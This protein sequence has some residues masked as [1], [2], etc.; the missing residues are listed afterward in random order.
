S[1][2]AR[3]RY[4]DLSF[5][6]ERYQD[7]YNGYRNLLS[8]ARMDGNKQAARAG[9][10]R[11]A[12]RCKDYPAAIE[13]ADV[14][15]AQ[16]GISAELRQEATYIK[17][18]SSLASSQRDQAM[19]LF[20]ALSADSA[21][22]IGAESKYMVIQNLYDTGKFDSVSDEVYAFSQNAGGQSYWLARAYVVLGD[23]FAERGQYAQ[24]KATFESLRDG[25]EPESGSD[26]ITD[27]VKMRLERL[28]ILMQQEEE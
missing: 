1:E 20:R 15:N 10:M 17:A 26:D 21:T 9:M 16:K 3:L 2:M 28:S 22:A 27:G 12:Y 7:A 19:A 23:S 18:K 8:A 4:A 11:A 24:A 5:G 13:A 6:L 25:Y 14:V